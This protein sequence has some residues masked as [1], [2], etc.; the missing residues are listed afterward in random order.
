M[1]YY[2][3]TGFRMQGSNGTVAAYVTDSAMYARAFRGNANVG[4]TGEA[5]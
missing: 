1:R 2:S 3:G 4:G 5:I